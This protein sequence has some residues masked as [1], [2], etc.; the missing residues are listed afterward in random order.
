MKLLSILTLALT[1]PLS[2]P[3]SS[4][5]SLRLINRNYIINN[6]NNRNLYR[7]YSNSNINNINNDNDINNK[8]RKV[9]L[10]PRVYLSLS[11]DI[12]TYTDLD[13]DI[14]HYLG[15]VLRYII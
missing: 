2:S 14:S 6:N 5:L 10:L 9:H 15:T 12:N 3:L 1:T 4:P 8:K 13:T 11:L 7:L